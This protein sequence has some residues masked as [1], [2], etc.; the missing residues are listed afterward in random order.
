MKL[1]KR[2]YRYLKVGFPLWISW[3]S[4]V[5]AQ[6]VPDT[7]LP[8]N[9]IVNL[10]GQIQ[11]ITGGTEAGGNLFHSFDRFN[12]LTGETAYFDNTLTIDNIITRITGGQLSNI[13]GL[14]R[15]NGTANFFLLNPSGIVFG[16]N[17]SLDIGGSFFGSTA[18]SLVFEDGSFYSATEPNTPP[19]LT[20]NVPVGLQMETNPGS[21]VNRSTSTS[22][23]NSPT[24]VIPF[25]LPPDLNFT[26]VGLE[27]QPGQT[28]ALIGGDIQLTGVNLT[29][30]NGH[31]F[32]GSVASEGLVDF[33]FTPL[34][35]NFNNNGIDNFGNISLSDGSFINTSGIGGGNV[36]IRGRNVTLNNSRIFALTLGNIDGRGIDINARQLLVGGGA[37]ISNATLGDGRG[38]DVNIL[39]ESVDLGGLGLAS[40]RQFVSNYLISRT[41]NPFNPG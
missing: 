38:G 35:V 40:Y 27:V 8:N 7:T 26:Q 19:L 33:T 29:A 28:I 36:D 3:I 23:F 41:F 21:I 37:Q 30:S 15:A 16:E 31:I 18:E 24:P 39:A 25:S 4:S 32:L 20:I 14:I 17:A 34:G 12:I 1:P 6:I 2:S 5:S 13:D 11:R 10:Q 22:A 9:S